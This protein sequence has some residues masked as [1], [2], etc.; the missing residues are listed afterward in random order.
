MIAEECRELAT[1]WLS[2]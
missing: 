1:A 2:W